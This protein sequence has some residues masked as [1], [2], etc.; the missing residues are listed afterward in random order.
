MFYPAQPEVLRAQILGFLAEAEPGV[1]P[2]EDAPKALIAPHAGTV[3]SGP[4]AASAYARLRAMAGRVERVVLLGPSHRVAM[5]GLAAPSVDAFDTPLG[6]V[7]VDVEAV[8][9]LVARGLVHV[10]DEAHRREH[11]LE[12]HLPFLQ[13]VLPTFKLVP[14]VVGPCPPSEVSAALDAVWGGPETLIVVS[15]DL[16]HYHPYLEARAL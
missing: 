6:A 7:P 9:D 11:S 12:V 3:Y 1:R 14:L 16:S 15:S 10:D 4:V 8:A 2:H 13:A 5:R